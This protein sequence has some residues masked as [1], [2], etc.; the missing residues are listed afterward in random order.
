MIRK[1]TSAGFTIIELL[2]AVVIIG[3]L[4]AIAVPSYRSYV[5]RTKRTVAKTAISDVIAK[6]ESYSVDHKRYT[7]DF[8]RLGYAGGA[9]GSTAYVNGRGDISL[10]S[11]NALYRLQLLGTGGTL[12]SCSGL[13]GSP[14]NFAFVVLATP[15]NSTTDRRCG[16]ICM[17][18]NG[19]RG[20]A[21][22]AEACWGR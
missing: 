7:G 21:G 1:Q 16:A 3:I 4:S 18:S 2:I 8:S 20:A 12:S 11:T 13:S 15:V 17:S 19:D 22:G 9:S 10:S 5:E 6:Q 14:T